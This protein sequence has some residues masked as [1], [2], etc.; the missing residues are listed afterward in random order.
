MLIDHIG[1]FIPGMPIYLRWVGR[2]SAP[3]FFY[4]SALAMHY[5][6]DR[7]KYLLKLY[8]SSIIMGI[9]DAILIE[10]DNMPNSQ[11]LYYITNNIFRVIFT[12]AI[13]VSIIDKIIENKK[14]GY[15]L[16]LY[17]VLWQIVS[18]IVIIPN[19]VNSTF[20]DLILTAICGSIL[21][22]EGGIIYVILGIGIYYCS[23]NKKLFSVFYIVFCFLHFILFASGFTTRVL[24]RID[25]WGYQRTYEFLKYVCDNIIQIDCSIPQINLEYILF[26]NYQWMMLAALPILLLYNGKKGRGYKYFFYVFYPVH[27]AILY[28]IGWMICLT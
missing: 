7:K 14:Q 27:I 3:I 28:L 8:V 20:F 9:V 16:L 4:C 22:L 10:I 2:I 26:D 1:E 15:R 17:Y 13:L 6:K 5:T 11:Y 23:F 21:F 12:I 25:F 24:Y 18:A 19:V